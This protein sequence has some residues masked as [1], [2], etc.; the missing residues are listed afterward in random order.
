[1]KL[2]FQNATSELE[3]TVAG[4]VPNYRH[5]PLSFR[6]KPFDRYGQPGSE[7]IGDRQ[8]DGRTIRMTVEFAATTDEIYFTKSNEL[9]S[10]LNPD[11]APIYLVDTDNARRCL[12]ET[13]K[14]TPN[15]K[16][17]GV[18]MRAEVWELELIMKEAVWED[19]DETVETATLANGETMTVNNPG[20]FRAPPI[21]VIN[22]VGTLPD[23]SLINNT[24]D[25]LIRFASGALQAGVELTLDSI[26]GTIVVDDGIS[27]QSGTPSLADGSG[28]LFLAPGD[29]ELQYESSY[30]SVEIDVKFRRR[31]PL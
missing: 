28:F 25:D 1:M 26:E 5:P 3:L 7:T 4:F 2:K 8:L 13:A 17:D 14:I 31:W 18:L 9:I 20:I 10:I 27:Q 16:A 24:T 11:N 22:P 6:V 23:F 21:I 30:G 12:I 19:I 29:N 15:T